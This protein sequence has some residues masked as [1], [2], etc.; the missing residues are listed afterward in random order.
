[1]SKP[2]IALVCGGFTDEYAISMKSADLYLN[3]L[4]NEKYEIFKLVLDNNGWTAFDSKSEAT[5]INESNFTLNHNGQSLKIDVVVNVIHGTPGED[6]KLQG[7]FDVLRLKYMGCNVLSSSLSFN[8]G[9]CNHFLEKQGILI[10]NSKLVY[11]MAELDAESLIAELGLPCFVKPNDAGSS[12]GVSKVKT[13]EELKPAVELAFSIGERVL[14]ESSVQGLELTCGVVRRNGIPVP[15]AVTEIQFE[16]EFFDYEAKYNSTTTQ[17][18][19]PARI[20]KKT[21][22]ECMDLSVQI[23][24]KLGCSGFF[25]ADY[26]LHEE[27]LYLIEVN[28]VPGMS[29]ASLLPQMLDYAGMSLSELLDEEISDL[30]KK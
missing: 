28:T 14:V 23:Y 5:K 21:Y 19:T 30:I 22:D 6:G 16:A 12:L 25:R 17:E 18:I 27:K 13:K 15:V 26:I 2:I 20:D 3:H 11:E 7:Y 24:K 9:F 8:K 10:P 1:M 4:S 29:E